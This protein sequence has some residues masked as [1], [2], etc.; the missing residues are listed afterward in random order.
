MTTATDERVLDPLRMPLHG[1]RLIEASAGTG[2][3]WTIAA[4]Y[5][6]LV[7]G[8]GDD[9]TC[10]GAPLVPSQILVMTFTRAATRELVERIRERLVQAARHFRDVDHGRTKD[11]FLDALIAGCSRADDPT[12]REVAAWR[13]SAAAEAMDDAAVFTIDAWVG[14]MLREHAFDSGSLFD[15]EMQVDET[16]MLGEAVRDY[17]RQEVYPLHGAAFDDASRAWP[18]IERLAG[19]VRRMAQHVELDDDGLSLA[20]VRDAVAVRRD[21]ALAAIKAEW[22][23]R[24]DVMREWLTSQLSSKSSPFDRKKLQPKIVGERLDALAFWAATPSVIEPSRKDKEKPEDKIWV[25]LSPDGLT[26]CVKAGAAVVIPAVFDALAGLP[27]SLATLEDPTHAMRLHAAARVT[28]RLRTLKERAGVHGFQDLL[29]RLDRALHGPGGER[30]RARIV[31]QYPVAMIDEF[32]D[33][34]PLQYR[35]FDRLY[36]TADNARETAL[37]L[38]G[39]PKQSIYAFRGADIQSYLQARRATAGRHDRLDTNYRSQPGLVTAVNRFFALAETRAE[40]AFRFGSSDAASPLPFVPVKAAGRSD[41]LR[42]AAGPVTAFVVCH[43][44]ELASRDH[45]IR[46]FAERAA[47]HIATSLN[48]V[49]VGFVEPGRPFRRLAPADIAVLVRDRNEAAAIRRALQR[50][51]IASAYLSD[52]ESVFASREAADLL[53]WLRAIAEPL[54]GRRA[55]LAFAT[56]LI[57][58]SLADLAALRDD[59]RVFEMRI[60]Q[61]RRLHREWTRQGVLPMIRRMLHL[62][63]LPARWM[64]MDEGE[65]RLTNVMHLGELLQQASGELDAGGDG[66]EAL[67]R[68]LEEQLAAGSRDDEQQVVRLESDADLVK[69]VTIHKSKGLEYDVVYLPFVCGVRER[70]WQS[71]DVAFPADVDGTRRVEF[72]VSEETRRRVDLE[73]RQEDLRV[74][75]VAL[76]RAR[77]ASWIGV[78]PIRVGHDPACAFHRSAF[79]YLLTGGEEVDEHAIAGLLRRTFE[80][81]SS[82]ALEAVEGEA[83][84]TRLARGDASAALMEPTRYAATFERD[85]SIGSFSSLVRDLAHASTRASTAGVFVDP[86]V[87]EE[88]LTGPVDEE[89]AA[90]TTANSTPRHRFP[91]GAVAGNFLHDQLEWL[92]G[93][94][95]A[96]AG[97][98]ALERELTARCE[99]Q[100]WGL[101]AADVAT[102]MREVVTTVL[103]P[104]ATSLAGLPRILPE[105]EFWFPTTRVEA[106]AVDRLCR[107]AWLGGRERPALP[108]RAL[109]GM[110]MGFADLVC[111]VDGR[112]WIV[113]YKSNALG[114]RDADYDDEAIARSMA[115]HRYDVQGS[116]YLLALHRLLARRLGAAYDPSRQLGGA[117][118]LYLRGIEGPV[119]GC[120]VMAPDAGWLAAFDALFV[121]VEP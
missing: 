108:E 106:A 29:Q 116:I 28:T 3:T 88:L 109:R 22:T 81:L 80:G 24:I 118:Y 113:D 104:L 30:L 112:Y 1:S 61:L 23:G 43:D 64:R 68:W 115:D 8:H 78:A 84:H 97:D 5:L 4:L 49:D 44:A 114:P 7:L 60:D 103:P 6:R 72:D 54:D 11:A 119:A 2:K 32:Q 35:V 38:I 89:D 9:D 39:D 20:A 111:E 75:Y 17:W 86:A 95:F 93:E 121:G 42:D 41:V 82:V 14:R 31:E 100:G 77:H 85:W 25:R 21:A 94:Q 71:G 16:A 67:I 58:L 99:R 12:A 83:A 59:D 55:R 90:A 46:R 18:T 19:D 98:A 76:T 27:A 33:T 13:L 47:E 45:A 26:D 66:P 63:D 52:Q 102:W 40:G 74:L 15:E 87:E 96:L 36:R 107:E 56:G 53:H 37:L 50:R 91:R 65:R 101:R 48:D 73:E 51:G 34:S 10:F 117:L 120:H 62:L 70:R 79:G 105:M 57:G 110:L 92:A 69:V